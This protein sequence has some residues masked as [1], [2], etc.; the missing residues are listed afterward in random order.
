MKANTE[1]LNIFNLY[2]IIQ[3]YNHGLHLDYA[4]AYIISR[5]M[6][7]KYGVYE[8]YMFVDE[9]IN[10]ELYMYYIHKTQC[11]ELYNYLY[12]TLLH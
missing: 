12:V 5:L 1:R 2:N 11:I 7:L 6:Q 8:D 4:I 3:L 9:V 10:C